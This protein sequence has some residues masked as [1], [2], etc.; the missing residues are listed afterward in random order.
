MEK[1]EEIELEELKKEMTK[2]GD[3]NMVKEKR[4]RYIALR[5][6]QKAERRGEQE[7]IVKAQKKPI[8]GGFGI[9]LGLLPFLIIAIIIWM[10]ANV[11]PEDYKNDCVIGQDSPDCLEGGG[12]G[13]PLW[14]N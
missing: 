1:N 5:H 7:N 14:N 11:K 8:I 13:H 9:L 12:A 4:E 10:I 2:V 3:K 6:K